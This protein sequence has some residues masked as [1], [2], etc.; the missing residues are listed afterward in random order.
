[1]ADKETLAADV[2]IEP[3]AVL[4]ALLAAA[5]VGLGFLDPDRSGESP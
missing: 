5:P 1:V 4:E 2:A 3:S